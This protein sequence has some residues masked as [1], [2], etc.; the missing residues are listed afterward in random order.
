MTKVLAK[1]PSLCT[2]WLGVSSSQANPNSPTPELLGHNAVGSSP[3]QN[4]KKGPPK[5]FKG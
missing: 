1:G 3:A 2:I 5:N 4:Y